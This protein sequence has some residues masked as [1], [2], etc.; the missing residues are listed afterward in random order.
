MLE[1]ELYRPYRPY[2]PDGE[3]DRPG[4]DGMTLA[5]DAELTELRLPEDASVVGV[6]THEAADAELLPTD[7]LVVAVERGETTVTPKRDVEFQRGDNVTLLFR[8]GVSD[9]VVGRFG[10]DLVH[11]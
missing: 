9:E 7:V 4:T 1:E 3:R 8:D 2:G 11:Q 10:G 5:D 6:T